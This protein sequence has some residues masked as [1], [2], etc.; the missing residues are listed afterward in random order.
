MQRFDAFRNEQVLLMIILCPGLVLDRPS[1]NDA[2]IVSFTEL[3]IE[4]IR[5]YLNLLLHLPVLILLIE[6]YF[7]A[8]IR[9]NLPNLL[10]VIRIR[11]IKFISSGVV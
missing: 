8:V 11:V 1:Y 7:G 10:L 3:I 5:D 9:Q 4:L 6:T 2:V